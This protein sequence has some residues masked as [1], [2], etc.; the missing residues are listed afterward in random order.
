MI[1][2]GIRSRASDIDSQS[3]IGLWYFRLII[4]WHRFPLIVWA[5]VSGAQS[6]FEGGGY[7]FVDTWR[8]IRGA[9]V[10]LCHRFVSMIR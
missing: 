5:V 1:F 8:K 6:F 10:L 2:G 3:I 7:M 4:L 9:L